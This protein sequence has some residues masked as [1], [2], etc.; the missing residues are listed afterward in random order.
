VLGYSRGKTVKSFKLLPLIKYERAEHKKSV[1]LLYPLYKCVEEEKDET[2][3]TTTYIL[4]VDYYERRCKNDRIYFKLARFWPFF[5]Y[6]FDQDG[7][8]AY[9]PA[10]LPIEDPGF[11]RVLA[12]IFRIYYHE[13]DKAGNIYT[14]WFWGLYNH[15][16]EGKRETYHLFPL[17]DW[18][19]TPEEQKLSLLAG[20]FQSITKDKS[21]HFRVFYLF[22]FRLSK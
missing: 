21:R 19:K 4:F 17:F 8:K 13:K 3:I 2:I 5:Y 18:E 6:R 11:E 20:L 14:N 15:R 9:F 7:E 22:N 10:L 1:F 16:K 12:P